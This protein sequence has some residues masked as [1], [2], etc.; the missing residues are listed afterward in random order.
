MQ[1]GFWEVKDKPFFSSLRSPNTTR[2]ALRG[3]GLL[4]RTRTVAPRCDE[5]L[6]TGTSLLRMNHLAF[7]NSCS[8]LVQI[9]LVT[10]NFFQNLAITNEKSRKPLKS[11]LSLQ[12]G[13]TV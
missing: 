8:I 5:I 6:Y 2:L 11:W 7:Y 1:A 4:H 9:D 10:K 3:E 12:R 13:A